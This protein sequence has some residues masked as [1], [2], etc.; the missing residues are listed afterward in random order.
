[1]TLHIIGIDK[2]LDLARDQFW[3]RAGDILIDVANVQSF[4]GQ[5]VHDVITA[6]GDIEVT[7][8]NEPDR[9]TITLV[10]PSGLRQVVFDNRRPTIV[11]QKAA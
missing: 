3:N 9:I 5:A 11:H 6:G 1:M 8:H 4:I 10:K 2:D 7:A